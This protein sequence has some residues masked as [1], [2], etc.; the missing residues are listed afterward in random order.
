[1]I[2]PYQIGVMAG[3]N[4][5]NQF[6][7]N[8]MLARLKFLVTGIHRMAGADAGVEVRYVRMY[9]NSVPWVNKI[10]RPDRVTFEPGP[11]WTPHGEMF[12]REWFADKWE[13]DEVWLFN[14]TGQNALGRSP[15]ARVYRATMGVY[16]PNHFK[17]VPSWISYDQEAPI[18]PKERKAPCLKNN[19]N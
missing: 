14:A 12:I 7:L 5:P 19:W 13:A 18:T 3:V 11:C 15:M 10:R 1:M 6:Q 16:Q 17:L 4:G 8:W 2:S 9:G